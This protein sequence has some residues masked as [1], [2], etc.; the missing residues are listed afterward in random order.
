M[1]AHLVKLPIADVLEAV[2]L[3]GGH[4]D[5]LSGVSTDPGVVNREPAT[6]PWTMNV[7]SYGWRW[8]PGPDPGGCDVMKNE[9]CDP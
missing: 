8:S 2:G 9:V 4:D 6:P 3:P 5:D 1:D 7:S